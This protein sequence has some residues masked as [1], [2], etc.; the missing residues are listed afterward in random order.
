M[1]KLQYAARVLQLSAMQSQIVALA[2]ELDVPKDVFIKETAAAFDEH[3]A[4]L[5]HAMSMM[6]VIST[7]PKGEAS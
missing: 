1:T 4:T 3:T 6:T 5:A 2:M 7:A